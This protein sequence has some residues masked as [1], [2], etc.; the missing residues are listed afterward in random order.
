MEIINKLASA[1][2]HIDIISIV[3]GVILKILFDRWLEDYRKWISTNKRL[4]RRAFLENN[5]EISNRLIKYYKD[6]NS[7][8]NLFN[9]EID[10]Y[11]VKIPFL[12][13][14]EWV[15]FKRINPREEI[16]LHHA[17]T[18]I[19][20]T[21]YDKKIIK[22]RIDLGQNLFDDPTLYLDR[23]DMNYHALTLLVKSCN[24]FEM[25]VN[26]IRLEE[27]TFK[28]VRKRRYK[29]TPLRDS[30]LANLSITQRLLMKPLSMGCSVALTLKTGTGY[31]ILVHTRSHETISA[32][33]LRT[34][35]PNFGLAPIC[36]PYGEIKERKLIE[37]NSNSNAYNL[38]YYNF[39][40]EYL[41]ELFNYE[42]LITS[43]KDRRAD[44]FW[45]Y[46]L[47]EARLLI[48]WIEEKKFVLE[49]LG[50]GFEAL[51]GTAMVTFLGLIDDIEYSA[52]LRSKLE[53][54]WEVA[55]KNGRLEMEFVNTTS[56]ASQ[57]K[58]W[59]QKGQY[60]ASGAFTISRALKKLNSLSL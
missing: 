52:I 35:L 60:T 7:L 9:C 37:R 58:E 54:N 15:Y 21:Q 18:D 41:E 49:F 6:N 11:D 13:K 23:I 36:G 43:F 1:I 12:T 39:I 10:G 26:L 42:D 5:K 51:T 20:D 3:I 33:G 24:Y 25:A 17:E 55:K 28:M 50:F 45:F 14:K 4:K 34:V 48:K 16:L 32:G 59:L 22:R 30:C 29:K 19:I 40:K 53:L 44:P 38:L 57:L 46:E 8:D 56:E 31:Q 2:E 27:E 47:P